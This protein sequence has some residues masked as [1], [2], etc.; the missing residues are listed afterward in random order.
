MP[1]LS[2]SAS[3]GP[4]EI[5]A[6]TT[7]SCFLSRCGVVYLRSQSHEELPTH[8]AMSWTVSATLDAFASIR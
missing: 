6:R 1:R 7:T 3:L 5:V 4:S 2:S 8:R